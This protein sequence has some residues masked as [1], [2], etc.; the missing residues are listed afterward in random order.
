M[1]LRAETPCRLGGWWDG[2]QAVGWCLFWVTWPRVSL[3]RQSHL[4]PS[5]LGIQGPTLAWHPFVHCRVGLLEPELGVGG[6]L[7]RQCQGLSTRCTLP[8]CWPC[9][10]E[11]GGKDQGTEK[12]GPR[13]RMV[14]LLEPPRILHLRKVSI[15]M[16]QSEA[17]D[18]HS[19]QMEEALSCC[20]A[21]RQVQ[22]GH[23]APRRDGCRLEI[24]KGRAFLAGQHL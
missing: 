15:D 21:H 2:D 17:L 8:P 14:D 6:I 23:L 3:R 5:P 11:L 10:G 7:S 24:L 16:V 1:P 19:P 4:L 12:S 22:V 20:F 9:L 18:R 13:R